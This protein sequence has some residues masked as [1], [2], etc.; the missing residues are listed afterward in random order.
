MAIADI[1]EIQGDYQK[2]AETYGRIVD[3]LEQEWGMTEESTL[4]DAK[5]EQARLLAKA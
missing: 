5:R 2:A 3:L 4:Q 1:Y